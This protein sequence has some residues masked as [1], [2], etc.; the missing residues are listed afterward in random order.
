MGH[1]YFLVR[2]ITYKL[3]NGQLLNFET[4]TRSFPS[5]GTSDL[6][7]NVFIHLLFMIKNCTFVS[8][9]IYSKFRIT[10]ASPKDGKLSYFTNVENK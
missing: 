4:R 5:I 2:F 6:M 10:T 7:M 3:R 1:L 8:G 9:I